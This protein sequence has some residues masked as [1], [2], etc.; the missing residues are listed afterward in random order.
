VREG[1]VDLLRV[2]LGDR[3]KADLIEG[4]IARSPHRSATQ[5]MVRALD[6]Y[7]LLLL[8]QAHDYPTKIWI[9]DK[10]EKVSSAEILDA[11][12]RQR[13]WHSAEMAVDDC[14]GVTDVVGDSVA[15][16]TSWKSMLV[17]RHEFAHAITTFFPPRVKRCLNGLYCRAK[18]R[19]RFTEPLASQSLAEYAACAVS[20]LFF[21]DLRRQLQEVDSDLLTLVSRYV[22]Q[23]E[24][25]SRQME[26]SP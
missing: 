3:R 21:D 24:V 8:M 26:S 14:E 9:L 23:T 13:R 4:M 12:A 10:G 7:P 6:V 22:E 11:A 17:M 20:Y 15:M 5:K 16:V 19:G 1:T 2:R 25:I 18:E